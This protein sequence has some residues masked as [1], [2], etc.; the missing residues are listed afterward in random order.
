MIAIEIRDFTYN[1]RVT[2]SHVKIGFLALCLA[3][4]L[5]APAAWLSY[6]QS[7]PG[8]ATDIAIEHTVPVTLNI[9]RFAS[10]GSNVFDISHNGSGTIALHLPSVWMRQEVRGAP[11]ASVTGEPQ[12]LQFV[13]WTIPGGATVRFEA[14]NPG[15][16]T[17]HNPSGVPVTVRTTTVSHPSGERT[18]D[19]TI[20]TSDPYPLP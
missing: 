11:L 18:D 8:P 3:L 2:A 5:G 12:E 16:I 14:P 6:D 7:L 13:K 19:A 10:S 15:R 1:R 17:L 20:V 9:V 4:L